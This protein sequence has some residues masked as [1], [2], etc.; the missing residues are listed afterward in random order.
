MPTDR[1]DVPRREGRQALAMGTARNRR[2]TQHSNTHTIGTKTHR[3]ITKCND[4]RGEPA[5]LQEID[6]SMKKEHVVQTPGSRRHVERIYEAKAKALSTTRKRSAS[7][8]PTVNAESSR[9]SSKTHE[10]L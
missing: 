3:C 8:I 1:E 7:T 6:E 5:V 4:V 2:S 10:A 9:E